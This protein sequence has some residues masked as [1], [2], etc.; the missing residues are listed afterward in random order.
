MVLFKMGGTVINNL[1]YAD[2]TVNIFVS[3]KQHELMDVVV[4]E[5]E[6]NGYFLEFT[7]YFTTVLSK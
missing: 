3:M 7:K 2:G 4:S 6:N 5:S 1:K